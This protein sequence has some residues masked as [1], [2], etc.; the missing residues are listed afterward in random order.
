MKAFDNHHVIEVESAPELYTN[1]GMHLN[2]KGKEWMANKIMKI[3]KDIIKVKQL[4]P[5]EMKGR[6][7]I[8]WK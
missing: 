7:G 2:G 4:T 1:H 8:T 5:I 6:R 3:I